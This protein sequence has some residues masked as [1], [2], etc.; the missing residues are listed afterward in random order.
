VRLFAVLWA[1]GL[2]VA[3]LGL[4]WFERDGK[5]ATYAA[6][7]LSMGTVAWAGFDWGRNRSRGR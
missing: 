4:W 6:M 3:L 5:M 2:G 1:V 7:V